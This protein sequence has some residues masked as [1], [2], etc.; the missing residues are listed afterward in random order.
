[1]VCVFSKSFWLKWSVFRSRLH[2]E[3]HWRAGWRLEPVEGQTGEFPELLAKIQAAQQMEVIYSRPRLTDDPSSKSL[4][5]INRSCSPSVPQPL[6][7][8]YCFVFP[9]EQAV[10][11]PALWQQLGIVSHTLQEQHPCF[12]SGLL[13]P[14]HDLSQ[15]WEEAQP[16]HQSSARIWQPQKALFQHVPQLSA[17]NTI[18]HVTLPTLYS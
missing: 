2:F 4:H 5:P 10:L 15:T 8:Q 7:S 6:S 16:L 11:Q 12:F 9:F 17:F 13:P 1:M 18:T 3:A 14:L